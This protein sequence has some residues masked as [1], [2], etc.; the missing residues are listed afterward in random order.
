MTLRSSRR[1][2][3]YEQRVEIEGPCEHRDAAVRRARPLL[4]RT[5]AVE[6]DAVPVGV[7]EV[8]R[9]ADAVVGDAVEGDAGV[10]DPLHCLGK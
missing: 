10:D 3:L 9:L 2:R 6:L 4:L 8:E 7:S 1:L 5:V